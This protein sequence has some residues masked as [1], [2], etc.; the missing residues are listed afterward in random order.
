MDYRD[1][2]LVESVPG[3]MSGVPVI[4]GTRV[5]VEAIEIGM[6]LGQTPE[7]LAYDYR[8]RVNDVRKLFAYLLKAESMAGP[9]PK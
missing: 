1:C 8:I 3:R 9:H 6:E 4:K 5:P 2:E 7:E